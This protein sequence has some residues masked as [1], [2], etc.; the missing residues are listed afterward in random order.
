MTEGIY[1]LANDVVFDQLVALLNSIEANAGN[2]YPVSIIPYDDRLE[3]VR[4]EIKHRNNVE[5]F[6]DTSAIKLWENFSA[7]IWKAH[8]DAVAVNQKGD[9][10]RDTEYGYNTAVP[11]LFSNDYK[12]AALNFKKSLELDP[13]NEHAMSKLKQIKW[14]KK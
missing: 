10:V 7:D 1:I 2:Q 3:R 9:D 11:S 4:E 14:F 8:P 6:A 13:K 5:I 12:N